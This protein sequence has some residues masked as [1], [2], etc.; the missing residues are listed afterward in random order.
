MCR[1]TYAY[2]SRRRFCSSLAAGPG[3]TPYSP[4]LK[5]NKTKNNIIL[6]AYIFCWWGLSCYGDQNK[7]SDGRKERKIL[8]K[9][10]LERISLLNK[11]IFFSF[12][13]NLKMSFIIQMDATLIFVR[14][15]L[16]GEDAAFFIIHFFEYKLVRLFFWQVFI[17]LSSAETC[18]LFLRL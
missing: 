18:P 13:H 12:W 4:R 15:R 1:N 8:W 2:T 17:V 14:R 10:L 5:K 9:K 16:K 6:E 3:R 7:K 11:R